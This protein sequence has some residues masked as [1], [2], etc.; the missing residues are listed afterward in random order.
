MNPNSLVLML[1]TSDFVM[2]TGVT[3]KYE[4]KA[5]SIQN[6]DNKIL[7]ML[8]LYIYIYEAYTFSVYYTRKMCL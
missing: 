8:L 7:V 4:F 3:Q 2:T 6:N 5:D 1:T